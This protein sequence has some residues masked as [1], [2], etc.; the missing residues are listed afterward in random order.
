M[1]V[2]FL[3]VFAGFVAIGGQAEAKGV[4]Q[5]DLDAWEGQPVSALDKHPVF[6]VMSVKK[7]TADD[8]TE[9]RD[10]V[11]GGVV[12]SCGSVVSG[13]VS[14]RAGFGSSR[15]NCISTERACHNIFLIKHGIVQRYAPTPSGGARCYTDE[16]VRPNR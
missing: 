10:Y 16:T 3:A 11:N 7:S 12:D 6:L 2:I 5:S 15:S 4:R 1:R 13:L 8:G 14:G 9:I